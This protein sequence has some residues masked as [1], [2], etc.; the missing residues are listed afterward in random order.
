MEED[1]KDGLRGIMA[2]AASPFDESGELSYKDLG[3]HVDWLVRAGS[4]AVVWPLGYSEF[5]NLA[6]EER[7]K[8]TPIVIES[9][10]KRVPVLIGV[11]AQCA[12]EAAA[13]AR[14]ATDCGADGVVAMLPR[15]YN[16][17]RYDL[18]KEYYQVI[19]DAANLPVFV[20]NQG[21]PWATLPAEV[22]VQL[23][24]DI[25]LVEYVKEETP[26]QSK[27]CQAILDICG[28][29][30]RGVMSGSGGFYLIPEMERGISGNFPGVPV[31][32][33]LVKMWHLWHRGREEEAKE[34]SILHG[35]YGVIWQGLQEGAR[36]WILVRRGAITT[37]YVR[38]QGV[39]ELDPIEQRELDR[40]IALLEPHFT[41]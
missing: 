7:I 37:A 38:N 6:Y 40:A 41:V 4:H 18:V 32:D 29:D 11:S 26:P 27:S 14:R 19:R 8:G 5:M 12:L 3:R 34:L 17:K 23:C 10:A 15:G 35:A 36:K 21:P 22:I 28:D 30:M 9:V 16:T 13:Y 20:Q 24:R 33:V 25:D 1:M 31:V 39:V 2:I